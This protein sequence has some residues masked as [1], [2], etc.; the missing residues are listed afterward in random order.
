LSLAAPMSMAGPMDLSDPHAAHGEPDEHEQHRGQP[1]VPCAFSGL[2]TPGLAGA[3]PA[4]LVAAILFVMM[5]MMRAVARPS[6]VQPPRLRPPLRGPPAPACPARV[7][8]GARP[9]AGV[10]S[11]SPAGNLRGR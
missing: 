5:T 11:P 7:A 4:L 8:S 6:V 9:F 3:D 1:E 2:S 10:R